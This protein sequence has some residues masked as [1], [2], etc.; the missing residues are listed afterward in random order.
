MKIEEFI[1]EIKKLNIVV[2][3]DQLKSL[4]KYYNYLI[5]YNLHTNLTTITE[6]ELVYLKHFYDS[7]SLVKCVNFDKKIKL[8]DIGTG[9]GFP[10]VVLKIFFPNIDLYLM[11][12]NSKKMKFL[13]K[14]CSLLEL[15]NVTFINSRAEDFIKD[16]RDKFDIV[17][18][19]AVAKTRI[20]AELGIPFLKIDGLLILMK[21]SNK[22]TEEEIKEATPTISILNS[23]LKKIISFNLPKENSERNLIVIKRVGEIDNKYPR[24]YDKII[25]KAL[26]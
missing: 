7:L 21:A 12:S 22:V 17:V 9:A 20:I 10:G 13:E 8:L 4:E 16:N 3:D 6:K 1:N 25:K 19:R 26:K 23:V 2:T 5:N 15:Q 11:D 24:S 18:S 14:L